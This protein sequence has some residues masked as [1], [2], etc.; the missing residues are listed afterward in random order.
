MPPKAPLWGRFVA[1]LID[2]IPVMAVVFGLGLA[3]GTTQDVIAHFGATNPDER[4]E[5]LRA[6]NVLRDL[7]LLAYVLLAAAVEASPLQA[8]PGKL[9]THLRPLDNFGQPLTARRSIARNLLKFLS[10]LPLGLGLWWAIFDRRN[11]CL[12][13]VLTGSYVASTYPGHRDLPESP[14]AAQSS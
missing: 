12:H 6:R 11:R 5:F 9:A 1:Y 8:T 10:I 2:L 7:S 3:L 13:D 4:L 14:S